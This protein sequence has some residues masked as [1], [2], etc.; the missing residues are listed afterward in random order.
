MTDRKLGKTMEKLA[1]GLRINQASD[2]AAGLAISERMRSQT[3]GLT[4]AVENTQN[5]ISLIQTA[6]AALD[7]TVSML[8]RIREL[9]VQ[10]LNGTNNPGNVQKI[11][12]EKNQLFE[13]IDRIAQN[14]EFNSMSLLDGSHS[15][16][17]IHVGANKGQHIILGFEDMGVRGLGLFEEGGSGKGKKVNGE[18]EIDGENN[19][20]EEIDF[21]G[22]AWEALTGSAA[23]EH[24]HTPGTTLEWEETVEDAILTSEGVI[25]TEGIVPVGYTIEVE[26]V[27]GS[28]DQ[29]TAEERYSL[30]DTTETSYFCGEGNKIYGAGHSFG[31]GNGAINEEDGAE[32]IIDFNNKLQPGENIP[33]TDQAI[34]KVTEFRSKLGAIQ[35]RLE[36][37]ISNLRLSCAN[38]TAAESR[39][40]DADIALEMVELTR[41]QIMKQSG[42][43]MV[44]Q[45]NLKPQAVLQLL[46]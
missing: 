25:F 2:D 4:Q 15:R 22:V 18:S 29:E 40:R 46:G 13:E 34:K 11:Q 37:I 42:T 41:H 7:E 14:T 30:G 28:I 12:A 20:D 1:S 8:H 33:Q 39:I 44:S 38:I 19:G 21:E 35:N 23:E 16:I 10:A 9:N 27:L 36:H 3:G 32:Q 45:A 43:A 6:E 5:G 26:E 17:F 24:P 31:N